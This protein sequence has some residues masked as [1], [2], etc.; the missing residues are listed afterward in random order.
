MDKIV[1]ATKNKGKIEEIKH[2]LS[3]LPVEII[4]MD[5]EGIDINIVENGQTFEENALIK[6]RAVRKHTA[7][8]V[9]ADD[10]GLMVDALDGAPGVYSSR[11]AGELSNDSENNHKLLSML[12]GVAEGQRTAR[13]VCI[14]AVVLPNGKEFCV[15]GECEGIIWYNPIG[16]NGFGYDPLFYL[17]EYK[18]TMAELEPEIKNEIS[19]RAKALKKFAIEI[20]K[21]L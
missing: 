17:P 21:L 4:S 9:L 19:H 8:I 7:A 1:A 3:E 10:S 2:I 18:K 5:E 15:T 6:A 13:F 20:K 16:N 12:E 14:I 11:F